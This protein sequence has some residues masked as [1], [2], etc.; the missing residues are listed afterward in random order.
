M[1]ENPIIEPTDKSNSPAIIIRQAPTATITNWAETVLQFRTPSA[2]NMLVPRA[3]IRKKMNVAIVPP[4]APSSGRIKTRLI[5]E[6]SLSLSSFSGG[7][8]PALAMVIFVPC[9]LS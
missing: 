9:R 6:T 1:S 7:S 5:H 3:R 4:I 8:L 2:A